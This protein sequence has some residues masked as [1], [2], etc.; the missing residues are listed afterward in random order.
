MRSGA[1]SPPAGG[2]IALSGHARGPGLVGAGSGAGNQ[3]KSPERWPLPC[4]AHPVRQVLLARSPLQRAC[5]APPAVCKFPGSAARAPPRPPCPP[6]ALAHPPAVRRRCPGD[7][8]FRAGP[9]PQGAPPSCGGRGWAGRPG[10]RECGSG[11]QRAAAGLSHRSPPAAPRDGGEQLA[12]G[13]AQEDPQ[14]AGAGGRR[15]GARGQLAARAGLREE[16]EGDRK[17]PPPS[18]QRPPPQHPVPPHPE[19]PPRAP[20]GLWSPPTPSPTLLGAPW[21]RAPALRVLLCPSIPRLWS[22]VKALRGS[23]RGAEKVLEAALSQKGLHVWGGVFASCPGVWSPPEGALCAAGVIYS[24]GGEEGGK[25]FRKS[26][27][28]G[29]GVCRSSVRLCQALGPGDAELRHPH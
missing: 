23:R 26:L 22:K 6:P 13:R 20:P 28:L 7:R 12:G 5:A 21:R 15:G 4:R 17:G 16:A 1:L 3:V 11:G 29:R 25:S 9:G 14:P 19:A 27:P 24:E 8:D 10:V 2:T 18:T